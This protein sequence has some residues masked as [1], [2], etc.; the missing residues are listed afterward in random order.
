M[1]VGKTGYVFVLGGK[2]PF[3]RGHYIISRN[4]QRD[5]E[6]LWDS[7]DADGHY[8]VQDIVSKGD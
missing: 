5:G 4:G 3:H 1:K 6:N 7:R 2:Y 8:F